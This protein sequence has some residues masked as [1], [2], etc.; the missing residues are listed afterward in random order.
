V[1]LH[2]DA[3][4]AIVRNSRRTYNLLQKVQLKYNYL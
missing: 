2:A 3:S 4:V 1:P